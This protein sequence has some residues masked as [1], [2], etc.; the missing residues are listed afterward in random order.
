MA[1]CVCFSVTSPIDGLA[2][3]G[4]ES[5]HIHSATDYIG[6]QRAIR[7]TEVF[8]IH[9]EDSG[10]TR[11]EPVDLSRL[12]EQLASAC[13]LALTPHLDALK[14]AGLTRVGLRCT[15]DRDNVSGLL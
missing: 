15:I 1:F 12:A 3:D 9:T 4:I 13:C 6:T 10:D 14:E 2:M 5:I 7:W 11:M 8:F